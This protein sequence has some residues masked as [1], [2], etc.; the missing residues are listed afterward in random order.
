MIKVLNDPK[1]LPYLISLSI[2]DQP[3]ERPLLPEERD[4]HVIVKLS[5]PSGSQVNDTKGFI[6]SLFHLV[7]IVGIKFA[8]A[9]RP[10]TKSKLR[11]TREDLDKQLRIEATK[12]QKGEVRCFPSDTGFSLRDPPFRLKRQSAPRSIASNKNASPDSAPLN[13]KR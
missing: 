4:R 7:D 2:T 10:D 12:E 9:L 8:S 5:I 13:N 3:A 1:I 11:K 6:T